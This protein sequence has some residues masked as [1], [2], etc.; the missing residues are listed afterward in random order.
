[1]LS[2]RICIVNPE[3]IKLL[4]MRWKFVAKKLKLR[5]L[6]FAQAEHMSRQLMVNID[7]SVGRST[8]VGSMD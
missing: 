7:Q 1:M 6:K 5:L 2:W 3:S 4:E 8:M